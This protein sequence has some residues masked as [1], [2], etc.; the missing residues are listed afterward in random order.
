MLN[1]EKKIINYFE[2][3][4][5]KKINLNSKIMIDLD[6][7]SFEFV[8]IIYDIEKK[9]KKKYNPLVVEDFSN[10]TIKKFLRLFR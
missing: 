1:N 7:D 4:F 3:R 5:K 10:M 9:I 8:K 2:K 6:I